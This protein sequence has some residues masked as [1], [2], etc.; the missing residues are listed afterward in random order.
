MATPLRQWNVA[1]GFSFRVIAPLT[2]Y[3]ISFDCRR[4]TSCSLREA[5]CASEC[6]CSLFF[7]CCCFLFFFFF[8]FRRSS[9][10]TENT[11]S[12][13]CRYPHV[14]NIEIEWHFTPLCLQRIKPL[15]EE[16]AFRFLFFFCCF[17]KESLLVKHPLLC[18]TDIECP[19]IFLFFFSSC[20][21]LWGSFKCVS[22]IFKCLMLSCASQQT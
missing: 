20:K 1:A 15:W 5:T 2:P 11:H 13:P 17:S 12:A 16:S 3:S 18:C 7:F 21:Q 10:C 19:K 8:K 22:H 4:S 14:A 9:V 6:F